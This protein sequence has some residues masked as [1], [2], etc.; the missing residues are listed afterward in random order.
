[1]PK[2][3]WM[4]TESELDDPQLIVLKATLDRSCVVSGCA[5]SGKS[6]L[7]LIQAKRIQEE[8]YGNYEVIVYTKSL[9]RYMNAGKETLG[10]RGKFIYHWQWKE[11]KKCP[12]ADYVIVDEI[13]D[14]TKK[15]IQE[16][17][18]AAR[19]HCFFFGDTAQSIYGGLKEKEGGTMPIED[20]LTLFDNEKR[21]KL[22]PLYSNYR[23]PLPIAKLV[24]YVGIDLDT[25]NERIYKSIE[26][27]MPRILQYDNYNLQIQAIIRII[28][29]KNLTDVAILLPIGSEVKSMYDTLRN[30]GL[31]CEVRYNDKQDWHNGTDTLDFNTEN[32]KIMTYRSAKGL[33]FEAVFMPNVAPPEK[34][35]R[36]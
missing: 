13:Q 2:K 25:F 8:N 20:I 27:E 14:F 23:L 17:I 1:M 7:A 15:E 35:Y 16:F 30:E 5:G 9:C 10:L 24:Q 11:K 28:K 31:N 29:N 21:P 32:P 33:Q 34:R 6:V 4:V 26:T 3:D 36:N 12:P 19:K 22:F 18:R